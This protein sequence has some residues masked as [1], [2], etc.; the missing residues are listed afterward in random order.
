MKKLETNVYFMSRSQ[1]SQITPKKRIFF[2]KKEVVIDYPD[3]FKTIKKYY[4]YT[5]N[6]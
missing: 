3:T 2:P 6:D 5:R 4:L 1:Q